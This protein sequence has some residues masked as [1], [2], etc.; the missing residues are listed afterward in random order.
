[1]TNITA[2]PASLVQHVSELN[3][4][5]GYLMSVLKVSRED[6]LKFHNDWLEAAIREFKQAVT[7]E[8]LESQRATNDALAAAL[9]MRG[10]RE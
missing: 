1:M 4:A 10:V 5:S 6:T 3:A 9:N 2:D 7:D 8:L